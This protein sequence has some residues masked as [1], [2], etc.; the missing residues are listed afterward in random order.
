[1]KYFDGYVF[2]AQF[3]KIEGVI[4]PLLSRRVTVY[5]PIRCGSTWAACVSDMS[6]VSPL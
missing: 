3:A 4:G 5:E 1:M 6:F 2:L